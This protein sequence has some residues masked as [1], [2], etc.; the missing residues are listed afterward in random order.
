M[1]HVVAR[2]HF[3]AGV[4]NNLA[5][6][7][8]CLHL[9]ITYLVLSLHYV[10]VHMGD[11]E[12]ILLIELL[13]VCDLNTLNYYQHHRSFLTEISHRSSRSRSGRTIV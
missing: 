10:V 6:C 9:L 12:L 1:K 8:S 3:M 11:H 13:G 4:F 7:R 5:Q 2:S